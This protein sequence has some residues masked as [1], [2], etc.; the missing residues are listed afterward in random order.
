MNSIITYYNLQ[1][2]SLLKDINKLKNTNEG[3]AN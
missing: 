2:S 3:N 1:D